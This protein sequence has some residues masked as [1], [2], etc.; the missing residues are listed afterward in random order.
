MQKT[1]LI[2]YLGKDPEMKYIPSGT[3][4]RRLHDRQHRT[5]EEQCRRT[6]GTHRVVQHQ[7]R[8][9]TR[10]SCGRTPPQRQPH[11]SRRPATATALT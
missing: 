2:G 4:D 9:Q 1:L 11:L 3:S 6:A 5:L 10:R 7:G 8:W